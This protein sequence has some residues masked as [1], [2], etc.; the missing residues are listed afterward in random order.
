MSADGL[1]DTGNLLGANLF[2]YCGNNPVILSDTAGNL[3]FFAITA[4]FGAVVGAIVGGVAAAK[5]GGNVWKG[6][7]VGAAA[8]ALIGAGVGMAAGAA[9]AGSVTATTSAVIKGGSTLITAIGSGGLSAGGTYIANNLSQAANKLIP[10]AQA[11][12]N[13]MQNVVTKGKAGEATANIVKNYSHI[14]S[15]T[16]T[17]SYRIPDGL[18]TSMK[19]LS[20]VKNY[21]GT[22][23]Y[24]NQLKDF[25]M[26][27][28][29]NGYQMH[30]Y[31]NATLTGPLQNA[32]DRGIIQLFPLG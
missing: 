18:D 9:L 16:G 12:A 7:G 6:I 8:G 3:P 26:W 21:A 4:A 10:P 31:T 30:L 13:K 32:V 27:S 22:L 19:I 11:A 1:L 2:A 15:L 20:E 23:S 24:T 25:A 17:A 28:Q 14:E 5:R 29:T